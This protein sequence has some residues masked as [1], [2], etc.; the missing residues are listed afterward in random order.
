MMRKRMGEN[1]TIG[2]RQYDEKADGR[3][4]NH[5]KAFGECRKGEI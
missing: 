3:K 4:P 2:I 5:W 1:Q